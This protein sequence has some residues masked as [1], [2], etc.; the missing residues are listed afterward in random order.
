M[1]KHGAEVSS[2]PL[3]ASGQ[4]AAGFEAGG[5]VLKTRE[6]ALKF[7]LP[8]SLKEFYSL[9][10]ACAILAK[11]SNED[12]AQP[13]EELG[14]ADE[15]AHGLLRIQ[16]ENQGVAAWFVRLDGTDDPPVE[17]ESEADR[18]E[19]PAGADD[20]SYWDAAVFHRV[21]DHFS[22]FVSKRV[23]SYGGGAQDRKSAAQLEK[24]GADVYFDE[25][26]NAVEATFNVRPYGSRG[27][28]KAKPFDAVEAMGLVRKLERVRSLNIRM[29]KV[30]AGGWAMLKDHP[31]ITQIQDSGSLDDAAV[32]HVVAM[33]ALGELS[34]ANG[35][36][37]DAGLTRLLEEHQFRSL[38]IGMSNKLSARGLAALASQT[39]LQR[40]TLTDW[41]GALSDECLAGLAG[42]TSLRELEISSTHVGDR[43]LRYLAKH[44]HLESLWL[45]LDCLTDA[46][47]AH[48]AGLTE[49][50]VLRLARCERVTGAG[51][52]HLKKLSK[53]RELEARG[54]PI[55]DAS[56][57]HLS[58]LKNL[59]YLN[60]RETKLV[61]PG[62]KSLAGLSR[63]TRLECGGPGVLDK[64][65]PHLA[66]LKSLERLDLAR[67]Q[68]T[69]AGLKVLSPLH[70][71][72]ALDLTGA[73]ISAA[74]IRS[75][76]TAIP[77]LSSVHWTRP[78]SR[79]DT[80]NPFNFSAKAGEE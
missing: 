31:G 21:C 80:G 48:L 13:I 73:K 39:K 19:P 12:P 49:L 4:E 3:R 60:L 77:R 64:G 62:F 55:A 30:T 74:A 6:R 7:K 45:F 15:L 75:L 42:L 36:L 20:W 54:L 2:G 8:A 11:H 46:G 72:E 63:L 27:K 65:M 51:F 59:E 53:L 57:V 35:R 69:D 66:R 50:K 40:L 16:T 43:G 10:G 58:G 34:V 24:L 18:R 61:G 76:K 17:V 67:A 52:R 9:Q 29:T 1:S 14:D 68:I 26:G 23:Q 71:L 56:L 78:G 22:D 32:K 41:D 38:L 47:L 70:S 25:R 79:P 37:T 33:P 5:A 28:I 44:T